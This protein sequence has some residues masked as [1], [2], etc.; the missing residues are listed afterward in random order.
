M[1]TIIMGY[2]GTT[3][4]IH[5]FLPSYPKVSKILNPHNLKIP[6]P[7]GAGFRVQGLYPNPKP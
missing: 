7:I 4:G 5:S 1:D 6:N 3:I 2:T